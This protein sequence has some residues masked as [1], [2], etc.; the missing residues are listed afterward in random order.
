MC[1]HGIDVWMRVLIP[2]DHSHTGEL[3]WD[4]KPV[5]A[6][7][8]PLVRELIAAGVYTAGAC[9][10]HGDGPGSIVLHD[11]YELL[12]PVAVRD[13]DSHRGHAIRLVGGVWLYSDTSQPVAEN[14]DRVCG[15]CGVPN[16]PEGHDACIG[17]VPGAMNV[18]CGHGDPTAAYVQ[19][20]GRELVLPVAVCDRDS[21]RVTIKG[22]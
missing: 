18:C 2:A 14:P 3:L 19:L 22:F 15:R 20:D 6:C 7:I 5:D 17:T 4:T 16:T 10:G 13:E 8:A 21:H 11:G 9:C 1:K 12:L